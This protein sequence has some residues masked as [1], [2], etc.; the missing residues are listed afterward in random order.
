MKSLIHPN[1]PQSDA[2]DSEFLKWIQ[3][4]R[5]VY[6]APAFNVFGQTSEQKT[7]NAIRRTIRHA[8]EINSR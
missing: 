7:I 6:S 4:N 5:G 3:F 1:A 8:Q 2:P